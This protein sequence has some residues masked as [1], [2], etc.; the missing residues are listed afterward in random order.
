MRFQSVWFGSY[1]LSYTYRSIIQAYI[2]LK[3]ELNEIY[4]R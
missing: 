3:K 4:E 1:L 2:K